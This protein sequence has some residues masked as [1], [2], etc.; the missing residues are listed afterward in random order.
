MIS[1]CIC[2]DAIQSP[3]CNDFVKGVAEYWPGYEL[4]SSLTLKSLI[5]PGIKKKVE[6]YIHNVKN[7]SV[8]TG[9]TLMY[10]KWPSRKSCIKT[11][12]TYKIFL[13]IHQEGWHAWIP[14]NTQP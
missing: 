7:Y 8:K 10:N 14:L 3:F 11:I 6:E 12:F 4:P 5:M 2:S 1:D 9:C 13:L